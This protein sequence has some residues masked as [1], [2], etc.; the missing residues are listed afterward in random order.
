MKSKG[1]KRV[2]D[3]ACGTG[4]DSIML[5]EEGFDVGKWKYPKK[6]V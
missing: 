6:N 3:V 1:C 5:V 2:L 4:V